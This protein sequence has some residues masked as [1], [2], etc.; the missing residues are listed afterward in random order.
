MTV[1]DLIE[2]LGEDEFKRRLICELEA[3]A[4]ANPDLQYEA[5]MVRSHDL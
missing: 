5:V 2:Q 3:L 4:S 1:Q